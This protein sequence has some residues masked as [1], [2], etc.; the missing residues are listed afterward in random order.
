MQKRAFFE[1]KVEKIFFFD[2][3]LKKARRHFLFSI[4]AKLLSQVLEDSDRRFSRN[5]VSR[6]KKKTPKLENPYFPLFSVKMKATSK[7][8][9]IFRK[10]PSILSFLA[11]KKF[12]RFL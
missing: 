3:S 6:K 4:E 9:T 1:Q 8:S 5:R 12:P 7:I 10:N 11:E 2:F